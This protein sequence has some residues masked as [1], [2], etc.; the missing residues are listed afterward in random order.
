MK[1]QTI[2]LLVS[3]LF[4]ASC[5]NEEEQL[6][7]KMLPIIREMTLRDSVVAK[8]DSLIIYKLDTLTDLKMAVRRIDIL[9]QLAGY[10]IRSAEFNNQ[11]AEIHQSSASSHA[12]SARLY[13]SVLDSKTLGD[14][15][16]DDAKSEL[17]KSNEQLK[18]A[19][20]MSDSSKM[21]SDLAQKLLSDM[22]AKNID[23]VTF[24]G[25]VPRYIIK[26]A[27]KKGIQVT[28]SMYV[29]L[30]KDLNIIQVKAF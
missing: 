8:L 25:F 23:S 11:M 17:A 19:K 21:M 22:K 1:Y 6:K 4:L 9:N 28:D 13:Y 12:S 2:I 16:K 5:K 29:Y 20:L 3:I 24:R 15:S 26:G 30:S 10:Y 14:I 18:Q 7:V 27:D